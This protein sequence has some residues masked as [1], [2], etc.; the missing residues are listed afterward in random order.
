MQ[1]WEDCCGA[2]RPSTHLI[3][4]SVILD[5][6]PSSAGTHTLRPSAQLLIL[7]AALLIAD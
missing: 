3:F 7:A 6:N 2:S 4:I 1:V 5:M